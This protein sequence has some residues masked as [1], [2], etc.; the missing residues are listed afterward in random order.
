MIGVLPVPRT[1]R[2]SVRALREYEGRRAFLAVPLAL[3]IWTSQ[4]AVPIAVAVVVAVMVVPSRVLA[5]IVGTTVGLLL[6]A[7]GARLA[8]RQ[9]WDSPVT[10]RLASFETYDVLTGV[11]V[12]LSEA[13]L[14]LARS[15]LRR[16]HLVSVSWSRMIPPPDIEDLTCKLN[17]YEPTARKRS[18]SAEHRSARVRSVLDAAGVRARVDGVDVPSRS[19]PDPGAAVSGVRSGSAPENASP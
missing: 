1:F 7:L 18:P 12:M 6:N 13:Q 11:N 19:I 16:D 9:R 8:S 15:A 2:Q 14:D 3:G 10:D 5:A 4:Q 17:V